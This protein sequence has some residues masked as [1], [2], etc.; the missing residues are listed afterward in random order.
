MKDEKYITFK[1]EDFYQMMGAL[2]LPTGEEDCAPVAEKIIKMAEATCL[3]D[4]VVIRTKDP[5][6]GPALHSY[7]AGINLYVN[8]SHVDGQAARNLREVGHY[9][10]ERAMEA[11]ATFEM[12]LPD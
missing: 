1:R 11:D 12:K 5:F 6:A 7:A 4:A 3:E 9:F 8:L 2:G 10:H